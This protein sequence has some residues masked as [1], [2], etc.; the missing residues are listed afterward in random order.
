MPNTNVIKKSPLA[1]TVIIAGGAGFIGSHLVEALL[2]KD[3]RVIVLDNFQ[4]G[5]DSYVNEFLTNPKFA[6]YNVDINAGLPAEIESVD[7][8]FH[9][10]DVEIYLQNKEN[11]NLD[12]L[13]TNAIGTKNL[14]DLANRSQAK[15]LLVS[16]T[17]VYRG[18]L[19]NA[20]LSQYF[21]QTIDE[22]NKYSL[23]EAK[24]FAE[25]LV[26]EYFK[27]YNTDVRVARIPEVFGPKMNMDA[28]GNLG[29]FLK[30]IM[31]KKDL[32]VYGDGIEK[33][34]YLYITD[35]V[36][37]IIKA[38]FS[39]G[40]EGK[41]YTLVGQEPYSTLE[42]AYLLKSLADREVK[43][44]FRP[45]KKDGA[46]YEIKIPD[47]HTLRDLKWE[48]KVNLKDGLMKTLKW[49]GYEPNVHSF[50]PG[51]LIAEKSA[52][53]MIAKNGVDTLADVMPAEKP[54]QD[55]QPAK[56]KFSFN[57]N[58]FGKPRN[59][60]ESQPKEQKTESTA[61]YTQGISPALLRVPE[62]PQ[63]V[64][65]A[66]EVA[67][68]S[69]PKK[70]SVK[71]T[72]FMLMLVVS[73]VISFVAVFVAFPLFQTYVN[74][75]DGASE[76]ETLPKT[77]GQ[78]DASTSQKNANAA[79]QHFYKADM[80]FKRV[81]WVFVLTG[82]SE[83]YTSFSRLL[84]SSVY[85]SRSIYNVSKAISPFSSIWEVVRPNS[86]QVFNQDQFDKSKL[87]LESSK[88]DIQLSLAEF[89]YV[90]KDVLPEMVRQKAGAYEN[91]LNMTAESLDALLATVTDL[92]DILGIN[93]PKKYLILFQNSNEI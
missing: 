70:G 21:G 8:I 61:Q 30:D 85:F 74:A 67:S 72:L 41:I 65:K 18:H 2:L 92:P 77:L 13:L 86:N 66:E 79:F 55:Q 68:I 91:A 50:K 57:L 38:Q 69:P 48:P 32:T 4:T 33:E 6:I 23:A 11:I 27:K 82:K 15:F 84:T 3:A 83:Q 24:R 58:F 76:L 28:S 39:K 63:K 35:V 49:F 93:S 81:N 10:V 59:K 73:L 9:L 80:Y 71:K 56:K 53:K 60:E 20:N 51:K 25:A 64:E 44:N 5:K 17:D 29:L 89:K 75:K 31:E 54:V 90:N 43:I 19:S 47:T 88:N 14:L 62:Q 37:G 78:F 87:D 34:Y 45:S 42:V 16:S 12:L 46:S 1:P 40:S 52:E 7:Y 22:E 36:A 26:W